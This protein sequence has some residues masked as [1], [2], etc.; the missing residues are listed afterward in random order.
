MRNN[1]SAK[2]EIRSQ[3]AS[4]S[5][6][7]NRL[8][9]VVDD[10]AVLTIAVDAGRFSVSSIARA[11]E[12]CNANLLNLN[13]TA[14]GDLP[15]RLGHGEVIVE[16]RVDLRNAMPVVRSLERYGYRVL[17]A[18]TPAGDDVVEGESVVDETLRDRVNYLLRLMD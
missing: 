3:E 10:S 11:V 9:P 15:C 14:L 5:M 13:V 18:V 6:S 17:E 2:E 16:L 4:A 8:F 7:L 1:L 12:D